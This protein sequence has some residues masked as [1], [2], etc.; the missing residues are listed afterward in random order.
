M[1]LSKSE[2]LQ[3]LIRN[4]QV[5]LENDLKAKYVWNGETVLENYRHN[6]MG[7]KLVLNFG[8]KFQR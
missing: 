4:T 6:I 1:Y 3:L 7:D 8:A 5:D 2:A